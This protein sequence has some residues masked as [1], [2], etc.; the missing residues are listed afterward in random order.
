[1]KTNFGSFKAEFVAGIKGD[2]ATVKA[3]KAWRGAK[4]Q[5]QVEVYRLE[6]ETIAIE[7]K[8]ESATESLRLARLNNFEPIT[9]GT[10]YIKNLIDARNNL[11]K[12][13]KELKAHG[14]KLAFLKEQLAEH[15]SDETK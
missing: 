7:E 5:L 10:P 2:D 13:E 8:V 12:A 4:S 3:E 14:E 9:T 6:G 15:L 1:M 11:L